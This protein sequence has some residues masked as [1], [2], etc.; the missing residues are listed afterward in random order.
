MSVTI[1]VPF[2]DEELIHGA[3]QFLVVTPPAPLP[4]GGNS[5]QTS[6]APKVVKAGGSLKDL[7]GILYILAHGSLSRPGLILGNVPKFFGGTGEE[8]LTASALAKKLVKAGLPQ[9]FGDL[10]LFVCWG[11]NVGGSKQWGKDG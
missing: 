11:G 10:R 9:G 1:F 4:G 5:L 6:A 8:T 2:E 3:S 7:T